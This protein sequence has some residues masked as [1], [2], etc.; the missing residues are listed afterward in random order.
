[1]RLLFLDAIRR[2]ERIPLESMLGHEGFELLV[3]Q[4]QGEVESLVPKAD[5]L[6]VRRTPATESILELAKNVRLVQKMGNSLRNVDL[7]AAQKRG[8]SVAT[9]RLVEWTAVAEHV[10]MLM[11]ALNRRLLYSHAAVAMGK[12]QT[13]GISPVETDERRH[14]FDWMKMDRLDILYGKTLGII[15]LGEIGS[16]VAE[17]ARCFGMRVLYYDVEPLSSFDERLLGVAFATLDT[18]LS[19]SD[20][21]SLHIPHLPST[22]RFVGAAALAKM[23]PTAFLINACRGGVVDEDALYE[24]LSKRRI[25]GAGLDV[26][27]WEPLHA[28]SPLTKLENV[29][30]T[31]HV[32]SAPSRGIVG[33][34]EL[35]MENLRRLRDGQ[36]ILNL[37]TSKVQH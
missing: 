34:L 32:A 7:A 37:A 35:I 12:Y 18:I 6:V 8:I 31:P 17:R 23:K 29:I 19:E 14:A 4:D 3:A 13:I 27:R 16:E 20:F 21:V 2:E 22:D 10:L 1:L 15:G 25:A 9:W 33:R 5:V 30:M 24:A 11:L 36:E 26:F 28:E